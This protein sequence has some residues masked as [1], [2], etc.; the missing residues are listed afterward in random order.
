MEAYQLSNLGRTRQKNEDSTLIIRVS[1]AG[2]MGTPERIFLA[3]ADG[4]EDTGEEKWQAAS[5]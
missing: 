5:R 2:S 3:L 1:A 4:M